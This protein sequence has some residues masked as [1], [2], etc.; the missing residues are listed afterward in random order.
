M[1]KFFSR[2]FPFL[3]LFVFLIASVSLI[4]NDRKSGVDPDNFDKSVSPSD[5][6]YNYVS[7]GWMKNSEI[8]AGYSMW[9]SFAEVYE[10]NNKTIKTILDEVNEGGFEKGS[11]KQ[12]VG[13]IYYTFM[14]TVSMNNTGLQEIS[15]VLA[16]IDNIQSKDELPGLFA[17]LSYLGVDLP[18]GV[19]AGQ[20]DK[21]S[22]NV[23]LNFYQSGLGLPERDYYLSEDEYYKNFQSGYK[24]FMTKLMVLA[25]T[26]ENTAKQNADKIYD[27]EK[28]FANATLTSVEQRDPEKTY[29]KF[30]KSEA[31]G[32]FKNFDLSKFIASYGISDADLVNGLNFSQPLF[33]EEFDKAVGDVDLDTWKTYLKTTTLNTFADY[34]ST[35][36]QRLNF[37][38]YSRQLNGTKEMQPRWKKAVGVINGAVGE[39]LGELFV[40]RSFSPVAKERA[41]EMIADIISSMRT[42][43]QNLSWMSD[44][45][46]VEAFKK[47]DKLGIKIGYP[48]VWEGYA[49]LE[50]SRDSFLQNLFNARIY[51]KKR[52]LS[53]LNKPVNKNK[54]FM[55]PH[56]VNAYYSA[57]N[58]EIVFPAGILQPPFFSEEF[59]DA[60]NYGG[61]GG[62]IGHEITHGYDDNGRRYDSDG[63]MRNWWTDED[64]KKFESL[65]D[66]VVQQFDEYVA[67]DTFHVNGQLTLGENIADLGGL[68]IAYYALKEKLARNNPGETEGF[69]PEQRFFISWAQIWRS[70]GT[71]QIMKLLLK[72]DVH[73]PGYF[74]VL[75]P[76][77]NMKEFQE[78]FNL[79]DNAPSMRPLEKR[80]II[81]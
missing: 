2:S 10:S 14:D 16:K 44:E 64:L 81:W 70:K 41:N 79:S 15:K 78:A 69:T 38:F 55:L 76:I 9:S 61:I 23:I 13:D 40:E 67:I 12:M 49:G 45:T 35:D 27:L 31:A 42:R 65:A 75:G 73:A 1:K 60:L 3:I 4:A 57:S 34:I 37:D 25:G 66:M 19:Y 29:N 52:N 48:D 36:F 59:D 22:Q 17:E 26:D 80:I 21:A 24:D 62:V 11:N 43:L 20:D 28:R 32:K 5:N 33:F 58:N 8:P 51:G 50:L 53:E 72:T 56:Y 54:W 74:R 68:T 77:S 6:F 63:N 47:L 30:S 18:I 39:A 46:K 7:G 71:D